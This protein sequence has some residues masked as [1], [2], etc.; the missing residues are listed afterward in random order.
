MILGRGKRGT[1]L[2]LVERHCS[3]ALVLEGPEDF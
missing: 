2:S 3:R 1:K